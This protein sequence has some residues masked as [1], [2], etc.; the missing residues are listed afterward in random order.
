ME[1]VWVDMQMVSVTS[2]S[3]ILEIRRKPE[4]LRVGLLDLKSQEVIEV[5]IP[6]Y[7]S[8]AV[9][10]LLQLGAKHERDNRG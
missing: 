3:R 5:Y 7:L 8:G 2:E 4:G 6:Y 1:E 10:T 9:C